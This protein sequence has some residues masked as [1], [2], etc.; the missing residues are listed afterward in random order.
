MGL[1]M[2]M[3]TTMLPAMEVKTRS[4]SQLMSSLENQLRM[5][6]ANMSWN[7]QSA[8]LWTHKSSL[9]RNEDSSSTGARP[10]VVVAPATPEKSF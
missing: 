4:Y 5:E 3:V 9:Q 8:G 6:S 10:D 2:S 1:P 7:S